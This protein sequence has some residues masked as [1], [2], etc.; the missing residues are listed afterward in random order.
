MCLPTPPSWPEAKPQ[1]FLKYAIPDYLVRATDPFYLTLSNLKNDNSQ[2]H[3][4][5]PMLIN[6]N[7]TFFFLSDW[8]KI[9]IT[10]C[11]GI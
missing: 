11:C 10:G 3:N 4:S 1:E 2:R 8:Q 5:C 7:H 9:H 6:Q